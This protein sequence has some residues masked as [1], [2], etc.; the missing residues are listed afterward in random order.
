MQL[1]NLRNKAMI[2]IINKKISY[3]KSVKLC[4]NWYRKVLLV[5]DK[6]SKF[7][8]QSYRDLTRLL[9]L[10]ALEYESDDDI[11]R[12]FLVYKKFRIKSADRI[13]LSWEVYLA[14]RRRGAHELAL[15]LLKSMVRCTRIA[16]PAL[17][18]PTKKMFADA[19]RELSHYS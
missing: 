6:N 1:E 8:T 7:A 5:H 11:E 12:L 15:Q 17:K 10:A 13:H 18:Y 14:R 3:D 16:R 9:L 2:Q 19:F 4:E